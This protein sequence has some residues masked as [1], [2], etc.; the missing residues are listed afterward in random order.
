MKIRHA[1]PLLALPLIITGCGE[2]EPAENIKGM[3]R[4]TAVV[5]CHKQLTKQTSIPKSDLGT[6]SPEHIRRI[7]SEEEHWNIQHDANGR[8]YN[9]NV[10]PQ[11]ADNARVEASAEP[12]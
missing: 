2:T 1:A 11:D 10:Y 3:D 4:A 5:L 7:N 6:V 9:C 12:A 8:A